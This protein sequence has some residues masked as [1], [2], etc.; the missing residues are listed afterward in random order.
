MFP[1]ECRQKSQKMAILLPRAVCE[2]FHD[3]VN[4]NRNKI[5]LAGGLLACNSLFRFCYPSI[6]E[7]VVVRDDATS[8]L[9]DFLEVL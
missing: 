1:K 4:Q 6:R 3:P 7:Y 8:A 9:A 5:G 2:L